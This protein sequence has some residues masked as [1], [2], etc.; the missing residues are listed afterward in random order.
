MR[1]CYHL[2]FDCTRRPHSMLEQRYSARPASCACCASSSNDRGRCEVCR[3]GTTEDQPA[4]AAW[5][6]EFPTFGGNFADRSRSCLDS[7]FLHQGNPPKRIVHHSRAHVWQYHT[8]A[9]IHFS[10]VFAGPSGHVFRNSP[11]DERSAFIALVCSRHVDVRPT[12]KTPRRRLHDASRF[13]LHNKIDRR[14]GMLQPR[15]TSATSAEP[16]IAQSGTRY[17]D[18]VFREAGSCSCTKYV[19]LG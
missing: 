15:Q 12:L 13:D 1:G 14:L 18:P 9:R 17:V 19:G 10:V 6:A 8:L 5:L 7:E 11:Y 2:T 3:W 16:L 4:N